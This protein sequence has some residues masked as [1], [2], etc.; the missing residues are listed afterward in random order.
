MVV[1]D[2][3]VDVD[4]VVEDVVVVDDVV[5][6]EVETVEAGTGVEPGL[7]PLSSPPSIEALNSDVK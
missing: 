4:V 7:V 3:I 2:D 5:D 1:V 6:V